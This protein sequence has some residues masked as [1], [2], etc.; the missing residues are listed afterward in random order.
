VN[1]SIEIELFSLRIGNAT[2]IVSTV[3]DGQQRTVARR[4]VNQSG[5]L[6]ATPVCVT[7]PWSTV[8]AIRHLCEVVTAA[9]GVTVT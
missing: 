4:F 2:I 3:D 5:H 7:I 9:E 1:E 6:V 8:E